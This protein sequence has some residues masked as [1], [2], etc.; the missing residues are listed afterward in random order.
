MN[1][2]ECTYADIGWYMTM[3]TD[4]PLDDHKVETTFELCEE[5]YAIWEP[6][7]SMTVNQLPN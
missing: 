4:S 6:I 7:S 5:V 3:S 2:P 1:S